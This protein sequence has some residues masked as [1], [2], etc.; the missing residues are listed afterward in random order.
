MRIEVKDYNRIDIF[1]H[2]NQNTNP[3]SFVTTKVDITKLYN[4]C[5]KHKNYYATIGYYVALTANLVEE[6]KYRYENGKIYKYDKIHPNFTQMFEDETIGYFAC[7][8]KDT[9]EDYIEEYNKVYEKFI[10][11]HTSYTKEDGGEIW[12]SCEPWFE[13][14][15][16]IS[17]FN[18]EVTVPQVIWDKFSIE[19]DRCYIHMMIMIHHGF[20][21]GY[22]IGKFINTFKS[23][24]DKIED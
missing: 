9:Y 2:Y 23:L 17:P 3:F 13:F 6:F 16:V 14:T 22:H 10:N 5:K 11:T 20:A 12:L 4:F 24:I 15:G 18:K 19:N 21:D 7:E 1:N 8:L